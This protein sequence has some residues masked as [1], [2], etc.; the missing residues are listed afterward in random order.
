[1]KYE[2]GLN[3]FTEKWVNEETT[4]PKMHR[5]CVSIQSWLS[6]EMPDHKIINP[7]RCQFQVVLQ[8]LRIL[9]LKQGYDSIHFDT[10][11]LIQIQFFKC[12]K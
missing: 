2:I 12:K 3:N 4:V 6:Q 10:G 11:E 8:F 9:L 1:M 5:A 7:G